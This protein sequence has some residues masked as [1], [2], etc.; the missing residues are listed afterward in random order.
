[1]TKKQ[2]IAIAVVALVVLLWFATGAFFWSLGAW[3]VLGFFGLDFLVIWLAFKLNRRMSIKAS[4]ND[5]N[6]AL[7]DRLSGYGAVA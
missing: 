2:K 7:V 1:M 6:G 4:Q 5:G 3:P